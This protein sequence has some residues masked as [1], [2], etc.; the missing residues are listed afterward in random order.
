MGPVS[1]AS[2]GAL[3]P[4]EPDPEG[5]SRGGRLDTASSRARW[6]HCGWASDEGACLWGGSPRGDP[7]EVLTIG[8]GGS[9]RRERLLTTGECPTWREAHACASVRLALG[10]GEKNRRTRGET[11]VETE[12]AHVIFGGR[13]DDDERLNVEGVFLNDLHA[14]DGDRRW[15]RVTVT[16]SPPAP[17]AGHCFVAVSDDEIVTFGGR[18]A[19]GRVFDDV[20][21]L[22]CAR[23]PKEGHDAAASYP[24]GMT[25][26]WRASAAN[27]R[28]CSGRSGASPRPPAREGASAVYS[29]PSRAAKR[30]TVW[31]FGGCGGAD[32]ETLFDDI[33][34]FDVASETWREGGARAARGASR[35]RARFGHAC[36]ATRVDAL[37]A[38][39]DETPTRLATNGRSIDSGSPSSDADDDAALLVHGGVARDARVLRDVWTF[40]FRDETWREVRDEHLVGFVPKPRALFAAVLTG[41][42]VLFLGGIQ[43]ARAAVPSSLGEASAL[44]LRRGGAPEGDRRARE[45]DGAAAGAARAPGTETEKERANDADVAVSEV[46]PRREKA[47]RP[48]S[49]LRVIGQTPKAKAKAEAKAAAA[50]LAEK[51]LENGRRERDRPEKEKGTTETDGGDASGAAARV[52]VAS[53]KATATATTVSTVSTVSTVPASPPGAAK[54]A[55]AENGDAARDAPRAEP[56]S[57]EKEKRE[58][59]AA[60]PAPPSPRATT[61]PADRPRTVASEDVRELDREDDATPLRVDDA[62][63]SPQGGETPSP[64]PCADAPAAET[65]GPR[66]PEK[67]TRDAPSGGAGDADLADPAS[68][69]AAPSRFDE[70]EAEKHGAPNAPREVAGG[71]G[72]SGRGRGQGRGR[73]AA[74]VPTEGGGDAS[75]AFWAAAAKPASIA[76][77]GVRPA[78]ECSSGSESSS[79]SD[80]DSEAVAVTARAKAARAAMRETVA[81]CRAEE[82]MRSV[83]TATRADAETTSARGKKK[84]ASLEKA[85]PRDADAETDDDADSDDDDDDDD[86]DAGFRVVETGGGARS[87]ATRRDETRRAD[88]D[89]GGEGDVGGD[90]EADSVAS[91]AFGLFRVWKRHR[92]ESSTGGRGGSFGAEPEAFERA[93]RAHWKAAG[94]LVRDAFFAEAAA[95]SP[96]PDP[97][98]SRVAPPPADDR[99]TRAARRDA[100]VVSDEARVA[101]SRRRTGAQSRGA[102]RASPA[103]REAAPPGSRS[104]GPGIPIGARDDAGSRGGAVPASRKLP[105]A[106]LLGKM[107]RGVVTGGFDAGYFFECEVETEGD[108]AA[109]SRSAP[110]AAPRRLR[111]VLFSPVLTSQRV[112]AAGEPTLTL[113]SYCF[114][115]AMSYAGAIQRIEFRGEGD[116]DASDAWETAAAKRRRRLPPAAGAA[117]AGEKRR[118]AREEHP[119]VSERARDAIPELP[120]KAALAVND[121]TRDRRDATRVSPPKDACA[122]ADDP[123]R[124][125]PASP[126][127]DLEAPGNAGDPAG[128]VVEPVAGRA[129]AEPAPAPD[130]AFAS[131]VAADGPV[132][133]RDDRAVDASPFLPR[134]PR[135]DG[136]APKKRGWPKGKPRGPGKV[137]RPRKVSLDEGA[138]AAATVSTVS[139]PATASTPPSL[140]RPFETRPGPGDASEKGACH[141]TGTREK[142]TPA[143]ER[144]DAAGEETRDGVPGLPLPNEAATAPIRSAAPREKSAAADAAFDDYDAAVAEAVSVAVAEAAAVPPEKRGRGRPKGAKR[145]ASERAAAEAAALASGQPAPPPGSFPSPF[146]P[147]VSN[148]DAGFVP[149]HDPTK[150][151]GRGRPRKDERA[152]RAAHVARPIVGSLEDENPH[153]LGKYATPPGR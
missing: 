7:R 131:S 148:A 130:G 85:A 76:A 150:K 18:G 47:K 121:E 88:A 135:A 36:V 21:F 5:A 117:G 56:S 13:R 89:V 26:A 19:G 141:L 137:G 96:V 124:R 31:V 138:G 27:E 126:R 115:G 103:A 127:R 42:R 33:W 40:S 23:A 125:H 112:T 71:R 93:T 133:T 132:P 2:A 66:A 152:P 22:T 58:Q 55:E 105:D 146:P 65:A 87:P 113:P 143:R 37:V 106:P 139:T 116:A 147:R 46:A 86:D 73:G 114:P 69:G 119:V 109:I 11:D 75:I 49:P 82:R 91:R 35:P 153:A 81:R 59:P 92:A 57:N 99:E 80:S 111:G 90:S 53:A 52:V 98:K 142:P 123:A 29:P 144:E 25:C 62:E 79:D 50:R 74:P 10:D 3:R 104:G 77:P 44:A 70:A 134:P 45:K 32:G 14:I 12:V 136:T 61:T 149:A 78:R 43:D 95:L 120:G 68:T 128:D 97:S 38:S 51:S 83:R 17:R 24:S 30:G 39:R 15:R 6:G 28:T 140:K 8:R 108:A 34:A 48:V 122:R 118:R 20:H 60:V 67:E 94:P 102:P 110:P 151:R 63:D 1:E 129:G 107:V 4:D 16:G 100:S 54:E 145:L 64:D 41:A 9:Q 84:A 101:D 72:G